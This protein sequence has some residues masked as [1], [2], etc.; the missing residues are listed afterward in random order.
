MTDKKCP[1]CGL[2]NS[3]SALRCDCGYD[4]ES[5]QMKTSYLNHKQGD[6]VVTREQARRYTRL[7]LVI[8]IPGLVI[9]IAGAFGNMN[10]LTIV[11]GLMFIIG[12]AFYAKAKGQ[13]GW[14]GLMGFLW[15][16]GLLI[17]AKLPDKSEKVS[18]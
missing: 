13:S 18:K 7:S 11:G 2:W 16:I 3:E 10:F 8:G 12:L 6:V 9:Q 14:W 4:F 5:G 15:L 17:L 1:K